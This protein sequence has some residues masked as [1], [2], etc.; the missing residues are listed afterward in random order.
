MIGAAQIP[1]LP[2]DL[3]GSWLSGSGS[4]PSTGAEDQPLGCIQP[5]MKL[6]SLRASAPA[7]CCS[8]AALRE[9]SSRCWAASTSSASSAKPWLR[10]RASSSS[11]SS[12]WRNRSARVPSAWAKARKASSAGRV[13]GSWARGSVG[14]CP[15]AL[16]LDLAY[17]A[18]PSWGQG[19]HP[20]AP[21]C[22]QGRALRRGKDPLEP[23]QG[24]PNRR[25]KPGVPGQG[26]TCIG[27][28]HFRRQGHSVLPLEAA[29]ARCN[30]GPLAWPAA[31]QITPSK[32]MGFRIGMGRANSS[33]N[34]SLEGLLSCLRSR[35]LSNDSEPGG[36]D[37]LR[38]ACRLLPAESARLPGLVGLGVAPGPAFL[39]CL[40]PQ[41]LRPPSRP[42]PVGCA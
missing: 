38:G 11:S 31:A 23:S 30:R 29:L 21:P 24:W 7:R 17:R 15:S 18:T 32:A 19:C 10:P 35:P 8:S 5:G 12:G 36:R 22:S 34:P 4:S 37:G 40:P 27:P 1:C 33:P 42:C 25:V 16:T 41:R 14:P 3:Q 28:G 2:R 20:T 6:R 13:K 39:P 9:A 26:R